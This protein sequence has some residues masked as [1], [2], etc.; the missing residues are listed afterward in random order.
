MIDSVLNQLRNVGLIIDSFESDTTSVIRCKAE[1]DTGKKCSGWYRIFSVISKKGNTYYV[2]SYGNWK[3]ADIPEGGLTIEYDGGTLSTEDKKAIQEKQRQAKRES[4]K[5]RKAKAKEAAS[6]ATN[7]WAGLPEQGHSDYLKL[8]KVAGFSVRFSRGAVVIPL[9]NIKSDLV[10]L[11]FIY[12]TGDKKFLTGTAKSEAFHLLG[13]LTPEKPLVIVEGYATAASIHMATSY[14][15]AVAF[16]AG[17][18]VKVSAILSKAYPDQILLIAADD[19]E[20]NKGIQCAKSAASKTRAL[21]VLPIFK[22]KGSHTDF[23]DLHVSEGLPAVTTQ[24]NKALQLTSTGTQL[25]TKTIN[26]LTQASGFSVNDQGVFYSNPNDEDSDEAGFRVCARLDVLAWARVKDDE[27]WSLLIR[28]LNR[29]ARPVELLLSAGL[30]ASDSTSRLLEPLYVSGLEIDPHRN[31]KKRLSEY[32]QRAKPTMRVKLVHKL[33][34]S[35]GAYVLPYEVIGNPEEPIHYQSGRNLLNNSALNGSLDGWRNNVAIYCKDNPVVMFSAC[36]AFAS[37][38]LELLQMNTIGFHMMGESSLGKSSLAVLAGSVCGG[39]DYKKS[40]NTTAAALEPMAAEHS[41]SLLILDEI[42]EAD[43][44]TI[45]KTVYQLGNQK[46]KSRATDTGS[47]TRKQHEWRLVWLSNGEKTLKQLLAESGKTVDAGM[48]MRM[49]HLNVDFNKTQSERGLK[50]IYQNLHNF[51]HGSTL[52]DHI[53]LEV[54]KNHGYPLKAFISSLVNLSD[55]DKQKLISSLRGKI[56]AF[57]HDNLTDKASGQARRA[58][59][60]FALV[61]CCGELATHWG[62]TGWTKE[63]PKQ[64]VSLLF[65]NWLD[66]RGGE[67]NSEATAIIEH[68]IHELQTKGESN[69]T[70]W[71]KDEPKVDTH[72]PRSTIRWG[73]RKI[74]ESHEYGKSSYTEE[75]FYI[76]KTAFKKEICKGLPYRRVCEL[77]KERNALVTHKGRGYLYQAFLPGAGKKKTDVYYI[78]MS[79]LQELVSE[80]QL[81]EAA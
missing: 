28:F 56:E 74:K 21:I 68:V 18:L 7:I 62:I 16:D 34:W 25:K 17:N 33:G 50:G 5:E 6:R 70:R 29:D 45:G 77:L 79:A 8:K 40:W 9:K 63:E 31:S 32:L 36:L 35:Q 67:G 42:K 76:F 55:I 30:F 41:D 46:G 1:G 20:N 24:I 4:E 13:E 38:L 14:P 3:N 53:A 59:T 78:K 26:N 37:P 49:L 12:S 2:G 48:E 71:D 81:D 39:L 80:R 22:N 27:G 23:N 75:E 15:V 69:F 58:A 54:A 66:D 65:K 44:F 19:D 10:G 43:P 64:A 61:S 60:A 51:A 57:K 47:A 52:S 11:Q 73:Y 72:Q